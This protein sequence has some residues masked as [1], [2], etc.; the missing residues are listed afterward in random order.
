VIKIKQE[1]KPTSTTSKARDIKEYTIEGNLKF[2]EEFPHEYFKKAY[3]TAKYSQPKILLCMSAVLNKVCRRTLWDEHLSDQII[4]ASKT[5]YNSSYDNL[6]KSGKHKL[7]SSVEVIGLDS[8]RRP[9]YRLTAIGR[10]N[11][12]EIFPDIHKYLTKIGGQ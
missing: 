9:V 3:F 11:L 8:K 6:V 1:N 5:G 4:F 12:K 7:N 2:P 10:N